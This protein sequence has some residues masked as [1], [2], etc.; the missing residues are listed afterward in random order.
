[1]DPVAVA[2]LANDEWLGSADAADQP[3][4]TRRQLNGRE[5][6]RRALSPHVIGSLLEPR[7]RH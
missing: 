2:Q 5:D 4:M 6:L 1:M 3:R 7:H